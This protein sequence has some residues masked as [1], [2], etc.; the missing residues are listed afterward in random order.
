[1]QAVNQFSQI[2]RVSGNEQFL[3]LDDKSKD[4]LGI[5]GMLVFVCWEVCWEMGN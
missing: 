5:E 4:G 3:K 1:M 2:L